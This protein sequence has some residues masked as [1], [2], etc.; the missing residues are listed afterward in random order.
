MFREGEEA[1]DMYFLSKGAVDILRSQGTK[2]EEVVSQLE[3][4]GY[5]GEF[6]LLLGIRRSVTVRA[7]TEVTLFA[8]SRED[9]KT[10]VSCWQLGLI[11]AADA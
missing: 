1:F 7:A 2:D 10:L 8:L 6:S 5:F 9:L 11:I 4:G 3:S